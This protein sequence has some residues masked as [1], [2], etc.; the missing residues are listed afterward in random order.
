MKTSEDMGT[1]T[2]FDSAGMVACVAGRVEGNHA[3]V[4]SDGA[5]WRPCDTLPP[6]ARKVPPAPGR[7]LITVG[8]PRSPSVRSVLNRTDDPRR[9]EH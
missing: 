7:A 8:W 5:S 3:R 4:R 6:Y 2:A 9:P 1:M